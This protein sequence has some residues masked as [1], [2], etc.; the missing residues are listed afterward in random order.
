MTDIIARTLSHP[1]VDTKYVAGLWHPS[2]VSLEGIITEARVTAASLSRPANSDVKKFLIL[3]RARSGS[4]L[5]TQLIGANPQVT[6]GRELLVRRVLSPRGFLNRLAAKSRAK[7]YGAKLLSYQMIQVQ[8]LRRPVQ[9]LERLAGD[10]FRFIHIE[11]DTFAQSL[12]LY[13]AQTSRIYHQSDGSG[14]GK[15]IWDHGDKTKQARAA[16][17]IDVADF[18]RRLEWSKL[19]LEYERHILA[20]LPHL[21]ISY[22]TDLADNA[23]HQATADRAF[24]WIGVDSATVEGGMKKI[25]PSD[26]RAIIANFDAVQSAMEAAGLADLLPPETRA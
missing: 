19:L 20:D 6:C 7:A 1:P 24:D 25:L 8:R 2:R 4:T 10:G 22:D 23:L 14:S 3:S 11:R 26:P 13:M 15:K 5:L 21:K 16:K 18:V 9:F 12:S 17:E